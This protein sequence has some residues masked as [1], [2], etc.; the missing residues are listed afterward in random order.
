MI[1]SL[2]GPPR[3]VPNVR[4]MNAAQPSALW[5]E[6]KSGKNVFRI[7]LTQVVFICLY[8]FIFYKNV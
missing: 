5:R 1:A 6:G 8:V 3:T 2:L 7:Q 4:E